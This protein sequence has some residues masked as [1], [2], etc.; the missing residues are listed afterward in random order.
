MTAGSVVFR[1][2]DWAGV[3]PSGIAV[4]YH[5][6]QLG[7]A[8]LREDLAVMSLTIDPHVGGWHRFT[9]GKAVG[10][11]LALDPNVARVYLLHQI[12][13]TRRGHG[14]AIV[15]AIA[16][17]ADH[18]RLDGGAV[19]EVGILEHLLRPHGWERGPAMRALDT[20]PGPL[21]AAGMVIAR[22]RTPTIRGR[23]RWD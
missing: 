11:V 14:S 4:A 19:C 9:T 8:G 10:W 3:A 15:W 1:G 18:E 20:D 17:W 5:T 6:R 23:R 12:E 13:S 22:R 21:A 7:P 16:E 2:A